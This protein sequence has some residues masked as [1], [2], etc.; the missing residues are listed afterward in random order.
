VLVS[1]R[2]QGVGAGPEGPSPGNP[3]VLSKHL[4]EAKILTMG[5]GAVE[6]AQP[7]QGRLATPSG[8]E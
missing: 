7:T 1:T 6:P 4:L 3:R 5:L 2:N 8:W